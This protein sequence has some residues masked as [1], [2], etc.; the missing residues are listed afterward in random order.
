MIFLLRPLYPVGIWL[1]ILLH[2]GMLLFTGS[3][4]TLFFYGMT[5][6]M[7]VFVDRPTEPM[8]VVYDGD[9]SFCNKA[10]RFLERLDLDRTFVWEPSHPVLW[11][12]LESRRK[13]PM[14][15]RI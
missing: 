15:A 7:L 14:N 11:S 12:V 1:S 8:T 4:F 6:A 13:W 5:A 9:C 2:S 3:T 10:R